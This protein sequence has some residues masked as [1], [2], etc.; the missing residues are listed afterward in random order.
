MDRR[1]GA[2]ASVR[3]RGIK[4]YNE[5][6]KQDVSMKKLP[7]IVII[8]DELADLM[9]VCSS[10][11]EDSIQRLTQ[12]ARAAGI[13]LICATQRPTT[14]VIKGTIKNN[15]PTR[16]AFRVTAQVDS[17]TILDEGGA[18]ALLGKGDMLLKNVGIERLQGSFIPDEEIDYVT[19]FIKAEAQPDYLM[20]H[21]ALKAK[22]E[23]DSFGSPQ[24]NGESAELLYQVARFFIESETSS[25]N[26]LQQQFNLGFNR[27]SRIV[28]ALEEMGVV[29]GKAGTKGREVLMALDQINE[30]FEREE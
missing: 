18:E 26:L 12:K 17:F 30:L 27:A 8:I 11:V 24:N 19:D 25:V 16:V 29:S 9:Q 22:F 23:N 10:D 13:H 3:A 6:C 1:Y 14:D 2:F 15:I 20:D 5:K 28:S 4:D 21:D 7:Y